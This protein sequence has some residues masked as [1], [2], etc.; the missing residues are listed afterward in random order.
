MKNNTRLKTQNSK[1]LLLKYFF[2]E[3]TSNLFLKE[4]FL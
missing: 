1:E 4:V 2:Y 3:L